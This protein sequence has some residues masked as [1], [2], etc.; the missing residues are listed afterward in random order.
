MLAHLC[1]SACVL[2]YCNWIFMVL[3]TMLLETFSHSLRTLLDWGEQY[4]DEHVCLCV[5]LSV[6]LHT[7]F[8]NHN[9]ELHQSFWAWPS[10]A[11]VA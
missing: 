4:C 7:Y 2:L 1:Y 10:P 6:S 5:G 9:S 8:T 11:F 3:L